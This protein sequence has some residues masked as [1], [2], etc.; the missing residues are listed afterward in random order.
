[1]LRFLL[2]FICLQGMAWGVYS[3]EEALFMRRIL[4]FWKDR[5]IALV[6]SQILQFQHEYPQSDYN[7]SLRVILGDIFWQEKDYDKALRAYAAI[8]TPACRAKVIGNQLDC[9]YHLKNRAGLEAF[10]PKHT[11]SLTK[12]E[13]MALYFDAQLAFEKTLAE[14]STTLENQA[15]AHLLRLRNTPSTPSSASGP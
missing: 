6:R 13:A 8:C 15:R 10:L 9:L 3:Q 1:M 7:D 5:D 14:P 4:E 12:E 2:F 11:G